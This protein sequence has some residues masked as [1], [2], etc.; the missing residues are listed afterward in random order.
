MADQRHNRTQY[1]AGF[2]LIELL[3][4]VVI[5]GI[6]AAMSVLALGNAL[7]K[8]KQRGT[9]ADMRSISKALETYQTDTGCYPTNGQTLVQ[10]AVFLRPGSISSLPTE[11][12]WSHPYA[13]SSDNLGTYTIESFGKDGVDGLNI[14]FATRHEFD[15]DLVLTNGSFTA[16]PE[17]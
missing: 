3:I 17:G 1:E 7:D 9:M 8:A 11:D 10:L 4:V 5:I 16:S 15:R 12:H 13:Y 14:N 2:S 6:V